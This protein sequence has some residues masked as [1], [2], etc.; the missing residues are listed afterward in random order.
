[1]INTWKYFG[2]M[3]KEREH[4]RESHIGKKW[5]KCEEV[6]E[7]KN[8]KTKKMINTL[9]DNTQRN[10]NCENRISK[11]KMKKEFKRKLNEML[12]LWK[13][14]MQPKEELYLNIKKKE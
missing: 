2:R 13:S 5:N 8:N 9:R 12:T 3:R 6:L 10:R 1:M 4:S 7:G 14:L 11:S